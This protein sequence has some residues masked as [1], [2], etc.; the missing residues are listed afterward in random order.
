MD[1][2]DPAAVEFVNITENDVWLGVIIRDR[3]VFQVVRLARDICIA[4]DKEFFDT[5]SLILGKSR[6][7]VVAK[8]KGARS[9]VEEIRSVFKLLDP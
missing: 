7:D 2:S 3:N 8:I 6:E 1:A 9:S 5:T 4:M